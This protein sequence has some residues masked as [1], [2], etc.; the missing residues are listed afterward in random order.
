MKKN[1]PVLIGAILIAVLVF[2]FRNNKAETAEIQGSVNLVDAVAFSELAN[3]KEAFLLDVHIPEQAHIPGTDAIIAYN[4]ISENQNQLPEDKDTPILV[5]CRSGSMSAQAA[6]DIVELGYSQVYDLE[7]G[8]NAYREAN[9]EVTITPENQNLGEVIFG[10]VPTT[11]FTLTNFTPAPL[12]IT[13]VSTSCGCTKAGVEKEKLD[14]YESTQVK[15]SF[16]PA[17]HKDDTDLGDLTRT[18]YIETDNPNFPK[19]EST[20]TANVIR[21]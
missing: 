18:I 6:K 10:D 19:L 17:V 11:S 7:G 9:A 13:R 12:T 2:W 16:D 15:V 8:I 21:K 20:I 4:Q 5:Y 1:Y 3:D 14:A